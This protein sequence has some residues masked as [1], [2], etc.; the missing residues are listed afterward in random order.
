MH[1]VKKTTAGDSEAL[2]DIPTNH[3]ITI[4]FEDGVVRVEPNPAPERGRVVKPG[5]TVTWSF[6]ETRNLQ[7]VFRQFVDL[8]E[9]GRERGS[10]RRNSTPQ[11]PLRILPPPGKGVIVGTIAWDVPQGATSR[12][13]IYR[14]FE[15]GRDLKVNEENGAGIDIP[16][17][18]PQ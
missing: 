5:H 14:V 4:R 16:R 18:P 7:V 6:E 10:T 1:E 8:D 3:I 2:A 15:D 9:N 12:R 11:G 17:T 13:F